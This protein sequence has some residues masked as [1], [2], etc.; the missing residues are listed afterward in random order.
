MILSMTSIFFTVMNTKL[1]LREKL[2]R[3]TKSVLFR[4]ILLLIFLNVADLFFTLRAFSQGATEFNPLMKMIFEESLVL[5]SLVEVG[6]VSLAAL[7]LF[8]F[9]KSAVARTGV[10][11]ATTVYAGVFFYH[12]YF[13]KFW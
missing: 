7:L 8:N 12:L 9:R 4:T 13:F 5:G 10:T 1:V 2:V 11:F 6:L 3:L